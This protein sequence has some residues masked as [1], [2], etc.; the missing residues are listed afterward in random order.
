M[1]NTI[2]TIFESID[3]NLVRLLMNAMVAYFIVIAVKNVITTVYNH[4]V[5]RSSEHV[6]IGTVIRIGSATGYHDCK[7]TSVNFRYIVVENEDIKILVPI[8]DIY[9]RM[10]KLPK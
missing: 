1:E 3:S 8:H 9:E 4:M 2:I 5:F 6:C 7:I 10:W